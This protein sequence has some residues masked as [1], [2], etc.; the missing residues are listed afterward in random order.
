[1]CIGVFA[2]CSQT[3]PDGHS[4]TGTGSEAAAVSRPSIAS[5]QHQSALTASQRGREERPTAAITYTEVERRERNE[6]PARAHTTRLSI[7]MD[8]SSDCAVRWGKRSS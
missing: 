2:D 1:M 5:S 8:E 6:G 4:L 3:A 7:H